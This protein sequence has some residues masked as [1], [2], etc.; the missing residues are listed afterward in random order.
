MIYLDHHATTPVDPQVL[1]T[2]LPYFG[3]HFGNPASRNH[4]YGWAA[5][6]AV[7]TARAQVAALLNANAKEIVFTSGATEANNLAL[8]GVTDLYEG[9][10]RHVVT[11]AIEHK[12]VLDVLPEIERRGGTVS[13]VEVDGTGRVDPAR[14]AALIRPETVLVSVMHAN[15]EVGTIQDVAAIGA[16]CKERGVFFHVDAAQTVGQIP[17]D[18]QAM[19][20]DLLSLSGHKCYGPKGVGALYV[21]RRSPRVRLHPQSYGGGQER[22]MRSGTLNVPG[23][24]GLGAACELAGTVMADE[25]VRLAALR[26]RLLAGLRQLVPDLVLNGHPTARLPHNLHVSFRGVAGETL[27]MNLRGVAVSS[28]SACTSASLEPSH[29][30]KAMGV[31]NEL[32]HGSLRFGLGRGTTAAAIDETIRLVGEQVR[33][34]QATEAR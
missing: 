18:V 27:M 2:M 28:G 13:L 32:A 29:V 6:Q 26:D 10:G 15:N 11:T 34:L 30:L 14:V 4:A 5:E 12:A 19:G 3:E 16:L 20:I 8:L 24:V 7:E 22:G 17:V 25:A 9:K 23:I 1:A 21:R 33:R 31:P